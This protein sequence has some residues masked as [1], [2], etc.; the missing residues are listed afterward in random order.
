MRRAAPADSTL[1]VDLDS[2]LLE[3]PLPTPTSKPSGTSTLS[4][5]SQVPGASFS[6]QQTNINKVMIVNMGNLEQSVDAWASRLETSSLGKIQS[7]INFALIPLQSAIDTQASRVKTCENIQGIFFEVASLKVEVTN[8]R[9][10][11]DYLK[12]TNISSLLEN[13]DEFDVP[14]TSEIP[15]VCTKMCRWMA[16]L[17][18]NWRQR[19]ARR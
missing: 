7:S 4:S 6:S 13:I 11:V 18:K 16:Q 15:L 1:E 14:E 3:K 5:S 8:P 19:Q 10:H 17:M 12:S 2:L 9:N